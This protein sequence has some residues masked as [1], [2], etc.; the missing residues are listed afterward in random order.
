[1][2]SSKVV[3]LCRNGSSITA[4]LAKDPPRAPSQICEKLFH[5]D[6]EA[7]IVKD[8]SRNTQE[9]SSAD[10]ERAARCGNWGAAQPS[11]LFLRVSSTI[12]LGSASK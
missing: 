12:L 10:L 1:M 6:S 8:Q 5:T 4:V 9:I 3:E 11:E 7:D 2:I